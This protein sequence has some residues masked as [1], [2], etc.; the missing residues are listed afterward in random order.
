MKYGQ[1]SAGDSAF[2]VAVAGDLTLSLQ[3]GPVVQ[4]ALVQRF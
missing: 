4:P 1:L 2:Q 3:P